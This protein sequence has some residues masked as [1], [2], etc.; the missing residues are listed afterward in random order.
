M[1]V[2]NVKSENSILSVGINCGF[3]YLSGFFG[4]SSNFFAY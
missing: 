4:V 1:L 2:K 3:G